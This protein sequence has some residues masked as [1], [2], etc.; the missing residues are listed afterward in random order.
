MEQTF[1]M[2]KPDALQRCLIGTIIERI[3]KK[4]LKLVALKMLQVTPGMAQAH[5][6]EHVDKPFFKGLV[7]FITSAPVVAM[8]IEGKQAVSVI[9]K[10]MGS[11]NPLEAA[12]TPIPSIT[13]KHLLAGFL[14]GR[15]TS[16]AGFLRKALRH[17]Y[18]R[19][20]F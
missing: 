1:V 3:E 20:S 19:P 5:Y 11:T 12:N 6:A 16:V 14:Q 9:R 7:E 13:Q 8:V 4:G 2:L 17:H 15:L 10:L 18:S